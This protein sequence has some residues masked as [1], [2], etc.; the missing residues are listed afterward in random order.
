MWSGGF[1]VF[2]KIWSNSREVRFEARSR[3]VEERV[4]LGNTSF[5]GEGKEENCGP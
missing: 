2:S 5:S 1:W 3:L 4:R